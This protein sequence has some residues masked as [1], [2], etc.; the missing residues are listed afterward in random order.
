MTSVDATEYKALTTG[1]GCVRLTGRTLIEVTGKD[2]V[3]FLHNMCTNDV[4]RLASGSGIE[5]FFTN[6]QGKILGHAYLFGE[7]DR[8]WIETAPGQAEPLLAHLSKYK[9]REDVQL[10]DRTPDVAEI[11][12]AGPRAE[13]LLAQLLSATLPGERLAHARVEFGGT[14]GEAAAKSEGGMTVRLC[15]VDWTQPAAYLV[16][17][18]ANEGDRV[19]TVLKN[20]GA[21]PCSGETYQAARIEAGTPVYGTDISQA[22]L[23]Q[24]VARD[25]AAI[26]FTKGCYIGQETVARIDALGH[27]NQLLVGVRF[28]GDAVPAP[29]T[30][31]SIE[32][33]KLGRVTS[34]IWSPKLGG[35]LALA[36]VR[37]A[38]VEQGSVLES[39]AG[40]A[41][42]VALPV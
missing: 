12:L 13:S 16:I 4:R 11:L 6:A 28:S 9:I 36:Y 34:A 24:E 10:I 25:E 29:E 20:A 39:P 19:T 17:C 5:A 41:V 31:L 33:K 40:E 22:N 3:S 1:V 35:P 8:I 38:A 15:R 42:V 27:V 37:R 21:V 7:D 26:S 18:A 2:R 14:G 30:E 23:P 32:G